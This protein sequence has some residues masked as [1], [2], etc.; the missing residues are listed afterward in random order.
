MEIPTKRGTNT[1][2]IKL[3][4]IA[5]LLVFSSLAALAADPTYYVWDGKTLTPADTD[6]SEAHPD[7][8]AVWE[9]KK[10]KAQIEEFHWGTGEGKSPSTVMAS[11][12]RDQAFEKLTLD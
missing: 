12:K 9:Y 7:S 10:D 6:P 11:L 3:S 4:F 2:K 8:W 1:V 5:L